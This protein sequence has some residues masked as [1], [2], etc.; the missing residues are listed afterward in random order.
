VN[1]GHEDAAEFP[2]AD[3]LRTWLEA[4]G[5]TADHL[6][7]RRWRAPRGTKAHWQSLLDELLCFGWIDGQIKPIDNEAFAVRVTPRRKGSMW[8]A[9]N[10]RR[11]EEL[12]AEG[13]MRPAGIAIFEARDPARLPYSYE[14]F[15]LPFDP[16]SE[17]R[18]RADEAAWA[19]FTRQAPSYRR[20][21]EYWVMNAKRPETKAKRLDELIEASRDNRRVGPAAYVAQRGP[22]GTADDTAK[23]NL[24]DPT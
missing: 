18:F 15:T 4:H 20:V 23:P 10:V 8:S 9:I 11:I 7:I 17:A 16:A 14:S 6:W 5:E 1:T 2:A 24:P 19:W 22:K 12:R 21:V 3:D 13:R